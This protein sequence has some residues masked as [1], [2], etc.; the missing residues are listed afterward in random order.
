MRLYI[1]ENKG[2]ALGLSKIIKTKTS[3]ARLLS[4]LVSVKAYN[5]LKIN[6]L[7]TGMNQFS[8]FVDNHLKQ[9][10]WQINLH[11]DT[12]EVSSYFYHLLGIPTG[13][14]SESLLWFLDKLKTDSRN[15]IFT[16]INSSNYKDLN[17]RIEVE[18]LNGFEFFTLIGARSST[19]SLLWEGILV[20][21]VIVQATSVEN[22]IDKEWE[23]SEKETL[24]NSTSDMMWSFDKKFKFITANAAFQDSYFARFNTKITRGDYLIPKR[25]FSKEEIKYWIMQYS[26]TL[27]GEVFQDE[28]YEKSSGRWVLL[29]FYPIIKMGNIV[30]GVCVAKNITESKND[31]FLREDL[32]SRLQKQNDNLVKFSYIIMH[33]LRSPVRNILKI[34]DFLSQNTLDFELFSSIKNQAIHLNTTLERLIEAMLARNSNDSIQIVSFDHVLSLTINSISETIKDSNALIHS[35][36]EAAPTVYFNESGLESIFL[37]LLTNAIKYSQEGVQPIISLRSFYNNEGCIQVQIKDNGIGIDLEKFGDKIFIIKQSFHNKPDS[38][39]V[40]LYLVKQQLLSQGGDI[41][42]T[43]NVG[44]G[45]TFTITFKKQ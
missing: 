37:N 30:G 14:G 2:R 1:W 36:F 32:I 25:D 19:D 23:A 29:T 38:K 33:D 39:G 35:N 10:Y 45:S 40:G 18:T 27:E 42:V 15:D 43:S 28:L 11:I 44:E 12:I 4:I 20:K 34:F 41:H 31:F 16:S 6:G 17:A 7:E 26:R 21:G 8:S 13:S 24:I 9:G 5:Y 22:S 3:R